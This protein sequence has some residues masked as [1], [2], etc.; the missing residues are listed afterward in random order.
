MDKKSAARARAEAQFG[1][2][3]KPAK[4]QHRDDAYL[5]EKKRVRDKDLEKT[6]RLRDLRLAKEAADRE[7]EKLNPTKKPKRK[8][9][10]VFGPPWS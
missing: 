5:A 4:P 8:R 9:K 2:A 1:R 7:A 3:D 10:E 6:S